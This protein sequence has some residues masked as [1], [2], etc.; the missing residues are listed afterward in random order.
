MRSPL[1]AA[2]L[3][4]AFC[5]PARA[6][7]PPI[8]SPY[9]GN[10][11][12]AESIA[13][14]ESEAIPPRRLNGITVPHHLLAAD[15]IARAFRLARDNRYDRIVVLTPDHF[16]RSRRPFA[17]TRR[18]F[19]TVFGRVP[20]DREAVSALLGETALVEDSAL[21]EREHGIG[22]ILP[23]IAH[24]FPG[25]PVVPVAVTIGS[26][27]QDWDAMVAALD[28]LVTPRT[29][30]VQSTDFSHYLS[31]P[32]AILRDQE[33]LTVIA[34]GDLDAV[35]KLHQPRHLDSR[36]S[37][38][39][40]M[41]LQADHFGAA[42]TVIANSNMQFYLERPVAETTSY[43]VQAYFDQGDM[44]RIGPDGYLDGERLCF[45]GDTFFGRYLLPVVSRPDIRDRLTA[46]IADMLGGCPLVLNLEGVTLAEMPTGLD[47]TQ[48]AMPEDLTLDWLKRLGV[49]A[50][51]IA[52]NH[53][54]D[55]GAAPRA[56]MAERLR[57]AGIAV[58]DGSE[59]V[60]LGPMRVIALT[61]L[62]NSGVPHTGLVTPEVLETVTRS[63]APPPLA[64]FMHWGTEY[65]AH[66]SGRENALAGALRQ[67]AVSL[68][69]GAHP[70]VSGE[71]LMALAGGESLLAYSLGNFLFDQPG[72]T[73]S[74]AVLEVRFFPQGT[75]FARLIPIPNLYARAL[76]LR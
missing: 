21:F 37:Q 2:L 12:F 10:R 53:S 16:K 49:V 64:A 52:N 38:Y 23:Y 13:A 58:V 62:D 33:T 43:I 47:D 71:R 15:L 35:E 3:V 59:A 68:I 5:L 75:F 76:A 46:E 42:P 25:T 29:L 66:P 6:E 56:A 44:Q 67:A 24:F 26:D 60:D 32:E 9:G 65:V 20:S 55:L 28:P 70:H 36:G 19:D 39:I 22:A 51:S 41:R 57:A 72:E 31:L 17:T 8:P 45:A 14:A 30:I 63:D 11:L 74:G 7:E 54:R 27:R 73:V 4:V 69:V 1:A 61:D 18:D 50:V 48:L 40:Q 34:A